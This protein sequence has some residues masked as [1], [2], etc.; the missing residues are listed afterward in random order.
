MRTPGDPV[1]LEH[2]RCLATARYQDGYTADEIAEF[3][4]V[5]RRSV[6][7]WIAAFRQSGYWGL[8]ARPVPGRPSQLSYTQEKIV[9]RWLRGSAA[10]YGFATDLWTTARLAQL[11]ADEFGVG[12]HPDYLGSWLRARDQTPQKP[13]RVPRERDDA[14]IAAWCA[15]PWPRRRRN[16]RR[17]QAE[18]VFVDESGLL[19]A[20]LVRRTWAAKGSRPVLRQKGRHREKV[21]VAAAL[22][23]SPTDRR[24]RL[25]WRTLPNAYFN[26]V[27]IAAF[28]REVVGAEMRPSVVLWDGGNLHR[29]D[30]IR[31]LLADARG[32]L[33]LERLP[34]Y[35]PMLNP[36][37]TLWS[38]L[39][40]SRLGNFAPA[41][42]AVLEEAITGELS[43]VSR[44]QVRLAAFCRDAELPGIW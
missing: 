43:A 26:N 10:E 42:A 4:G 30:P 33:R 17:R 8:A 25:V 22:C 16:A 12:F 5:T 44:D 21:S 14:A 20:P 9:L 36:I 40:Y 2:R 7:R 23:L 28:L 1:E 35:A 34:P 39:K 6:R 38:W 3:L 27:A 31:R 11:I 13:E 24:L 32:R 19:M 18:L 15:G 41:D 29:G 37:E